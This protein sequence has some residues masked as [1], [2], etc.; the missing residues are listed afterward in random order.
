MLA[1]QFPG[2]RNWGYDGVCPY[3]VPASYGGP[4]GLKALV[5]ACHQLEIAV[6]LDVD[7]NRLGP[8]GNYLADFSPYFTDLY[9][10]PRQSRRSITG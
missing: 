5:D 1:E 3:A 10:T 6:V 8:D 9:K 7:Y 2:E 4:L